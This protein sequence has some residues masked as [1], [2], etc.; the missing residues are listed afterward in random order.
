M[1]RHQFVPLSNMDMKDLEKHF[2][3]MS[4]E[5]AQLVPGNWLISQRQK[6]SNYINLEIT[7]SNRI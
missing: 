4:L 5:M 7:A 3:S 2:S 6:K 1:E